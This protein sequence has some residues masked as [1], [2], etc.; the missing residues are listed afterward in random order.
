[1]VDESDRAMNA[2]MPLSIPGDKVQKLVENQMKPAECGI[3][4]TAWYF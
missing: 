2:S 1:L 3:S 4:F